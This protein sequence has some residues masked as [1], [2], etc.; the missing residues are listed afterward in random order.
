MLLVLYVV[1]EQLSH[2]FQG[3][4]V[5]LGGFIKDKRCSCLLRTFITL[6]A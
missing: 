3:C 1:C 4:N 6:C 2:K 5:E